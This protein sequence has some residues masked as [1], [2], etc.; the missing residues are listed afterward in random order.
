MAIK[1]TTSPSTTKPTQFNQFEITY[2][3]PKDLKPY[4]QNP[5]KHPQEQITMLSGII[6]EFDFDVP[7]V[8]DENNEILKGH[9]RLESALSIGLESVPTIIR[10]DL[11][12]AQKKAIRI[13]DNKVSESDWDIDKLIQELQ[14]FPDDEIW[15]TGYDTSELERLIEQLESEGFSEIEDDFE[16]IAFDKDEGISG[17]ETY[18]LK[19]GKYKIP[20][21]E[22]ELK[23][24]EER[25]IKYQNEFGSNYGFA[26]SLLC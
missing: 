26:R 10:T 12:E 7:I 16:E 3:N 11:T 23:G 18:L 25:L 15:K 14:S 17:A 13:N 22:D 19:F 9:G 2:Q 6:K 4:K 1:R 5:K 20:I 8:V 24:L 21:S